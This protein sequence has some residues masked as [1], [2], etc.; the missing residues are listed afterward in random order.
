MQGGTKTSHIAV[1]DQ[2]LSGNRVLIDGVGPN[3]VG[4]I[5][6]DV[7]S[8]SA[9]K[10][11]IVFEGANDIGN[12]PTDDASQTLVGGQLSKTPEQLLL[13]VSP[14]RHTH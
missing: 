13:V 1:V 9:T 4:R 7:L 8:H 11:A 3:G 5:D 10:F 14:S 2:G 12:T 6:R